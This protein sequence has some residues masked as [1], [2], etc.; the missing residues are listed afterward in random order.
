MTTKWQRIDDIKVKKV[1]VVLVA[2]SLLMGQCK[3]DGSGCLFLA[4]IASEK[5]MASVIFKR[6]TED[7]RVEL[8]LRLMID[9]LYVQ[10]LESLADRNSVHHSN[11]VVVSYALAS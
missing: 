9:N 4:V 11:V 2:P 1:S 10:I 3:S 5:V 8:P 7:T 6:T